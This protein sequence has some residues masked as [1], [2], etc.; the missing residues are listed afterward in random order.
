M[1]KLE[2]QR[3]LWLL[4]INKITNETHILSQNNALYILPNSSIFQNKL[5]LYL[6]FT[7][8]QYVV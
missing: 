2:D 8:Q 5:S 3:T 6:F 1:K 7:Y 4:K